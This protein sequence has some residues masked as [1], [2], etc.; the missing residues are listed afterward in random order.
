MSGAPPET[1]PK[2]TERT[3]GGS[4]LAKMMGIKES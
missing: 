2:K 3:E 4:V 1:A